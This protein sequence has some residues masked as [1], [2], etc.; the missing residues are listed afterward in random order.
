MMI[1]RIVVVELE[2]QAF[3]VED[4]EILIDEATEALIVGEVMG[5]QVVFEALKVVV[6]T[7]KVQVV[8]DRMILIYV[9]AMDVVLV[10]ETMEAHVVEDIAILFDF[11]AKK[12]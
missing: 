9:E 11:E 5:P 10:V 4:A 2:S 8:Q 12:P 1:I 6:E 3:A 7:M